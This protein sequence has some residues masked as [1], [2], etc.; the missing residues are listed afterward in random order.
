M[1][2]HAE[3]GHGLFLN[4]FPPVIAVRFR[5]DGFSLFPENRRRILPFFP[6]NG[7]VTSYYMGRRAQLQEKY[8]ETCRRG[9]RGRFRPC[10]S[11]RRTIRRNALALA[12]A[13][14]DR[15][16]MRGDMA[17]ACVDRT[18]L[19]PR[20]RGPTSGLKSVPATRPNPPPRQKKLTP[21]RFRPKA[22]NS[23]S[24]SS[25][26]LIRR[27]PAPLGFLAVP[28]LG[29]NPPVSPL[30]LRDSPLCT[31]GPLEVAIPPTRHL[32]SGPPPFA[33]ERQMPPAA[34]FLCA[35]KEMGERK[36]PGA[37]PPGKML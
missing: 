34:P 20:R 9:F 15:A 1:G 29:G 3:K 6:Q 10:R 4:C 35:D 22:E 33:Q 5:P 25:F 2:T 12:R 31:R 16:D 28:L 27:K 18:H 7:F 13:A 8:Q 24:A 14:F 17:G 26:F 37:C 23:I 36:P 32:R 30:T 19:G 21:F 11:C